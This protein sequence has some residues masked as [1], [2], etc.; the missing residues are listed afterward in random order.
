MNTGRIK[1]ALIGVGAALALAA[2]FLMSTPPTAA[3]AYQGGSGGGG[4]AGGGGGGGWGDIQ[5][6][7][8]AN[9]WAEFEG[10]KYM[11]AN[12][13]SADNYVRSSSGGQ[14]LL[15]LCRGPNL[16]RIYYL[17]S[18]SG[19][20]IKPS[21]GGGT[22]P[23][24]G[25]PVEGDP[26][27]QF[28]SSQNGRGVYVICV[29]NATERIT[30][31][32][33]Q[34]RPRT[35]AT[36]VKGI[37]A[38][39]TSVEAPLTNANLEED[40]DGKKVDPIGVNNLQ[41]QMM[42]T[43]ESNFGRLVREIAKSGRGDYLHKLAELQDAIARDA[44]E[45]HGTVDLNAANQAGLAE[46][47]VLD[48]V[49]STKYGEVALEQNWSESRTRRYTC[50]Y[51]PNT[52]G[53]QLANPDNC[54]YDN[55]SGWS[56]VSDTRAHNV[57]PKLGTQPT[58][59]FWQLVSV[60]CN[61]KEL[62]A[63]LAAYGTDYNII[64]QSRT[65]KEVT[66]LLKTNPV[67]PRP[68]SA[69]AKIFGVPT[70]ATAALAR[71]GE[72][73]FYDKHCSVQCLTDPSGSGASNANGAK[74]NASI[75]SNRGDGYS[76]GGAVLGDSN[77]NYFE[78]FR[79]NDKNRI[80]VNTAYPK[81][82]GTGLDYSGTA[83]I[84]TTVSIW[85]GSTPR[86]VVDPVKG[87][88][89]FSMWAVNGDGSKQLFTGTQ[90]PTEQTNFTDPAR[91]QVFSGPTATKLA[92]PYRAFDVAATWASEANAPV[93]LNVK[94]EYQP[95]TKM[96]VIASVGMNANR[97]TTYSTVN[98]DQKIDVDCYAGFGNNVSAP[99]GF[100]A[101]NETG[102]KVTN[103]VDENILDKTMTDGASAYSNQRNLVIRF[104]RGVA[105]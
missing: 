8:V 79:N 14:G 25:T 83:P 51:V 96:S 44:S 66:T 6:W 91:P 87:G 41:N 55:W 100:Y 59:A 7:S 39:N 77:S 74:K 94:W 20:V 69:D 70:V 11:V 104:V 23:W 65:D 56:E 103:T 63:A 22:F 88:G 9:T 78:V 3:S 58:T 54:S 72:V 29:I 2:V 86:T 37:L 21:T 4:T 5:K 89:Q 26:I 28:A 98:R 36:T 68:T 31:D 75:N 95:T 92:G 1:K 62:D 46:G 33:V 12:H 81:V 49:E 90:K 47:G 60:H 73:G 97:S 10:A 80:T 48:I 105:E 76:N 61:P 43:K 84:A 101:P 18:N 13:G 45:P 99:T 40:A 64:S 57:V 35:D 71:T 15:D 38:W 67:A 53:T 19:A 16:L 42:V 93:V 32:E 24:G 30:K 52:N 50:D 27:D 85:N 34:T 82:E 102:S 17:S